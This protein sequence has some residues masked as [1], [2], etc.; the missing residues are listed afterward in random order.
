MTLLPDP[1]AH[2]L[3]PCEDPRCAIHHPQTIADELER[4]L[5][6]EVF[7]A[8][9]R[10][11]SQVLAWFLAGARAPLGD[12]ALVESAPIEEEMR[13]RDADGA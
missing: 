9:S 5:A 11:S 8:G 3:S 6:Y 7:L 4:A 1:V 10:A 12:V 2:A 13:F